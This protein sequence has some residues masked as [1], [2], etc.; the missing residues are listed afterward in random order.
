MSHRHV[1]CSGANS[2]GHGTLPLE[3]Q[4]LSWRSAFGRPVGLPRTHS[5][6]LYFMV[7]EAGLGRLEMLFW[8]VG[9]DFRRGVVILVLV[10]LTPLRHRDKAQSVNY[11]LV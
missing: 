11:K 9:G 1:V 6:V 5:A 2:P 10:A 4:S 7:A 3:Q 8:S